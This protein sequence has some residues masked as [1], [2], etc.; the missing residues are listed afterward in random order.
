MY[1]GKSKLEW[2][3]R[4]TLMDRGFYLLMFFLICKRV[5]GGIVEK[6]KS[7]KILYF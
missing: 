3:K 7:V 5:F 2:I 1:V 4:K 6:N